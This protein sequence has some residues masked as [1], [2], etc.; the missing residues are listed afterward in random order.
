MNAFRLRDHGASILVSAL[1]GS[2]GVALLQITGALA[3][4][5]SADD[6]TGSS[7]TVALMLTIVAGVFIAIATYVGAIV[8]ANTFATIIAGRTRTIALR[9][10]IGST[11][12]AE[13]R[14]VA[15]E[16]LIVGL[17]GAAIGAVAGTAFA[18]AL[19]TTGVHLDQLPDLAYTLFSPVLLIPVV[20]VV[21]TTWLASWIGSRRVLT[22]SPIQATGAAQERSVDEL[23]RHRVR[24]GISVTLFVIGTALLVLG[25]L[26]G[27]VSPL[28]VLIGVVGGILSFTGVALGA[29]IIMPPALRVVGRMLGSSPNAR[30]AAENSVRYPERSSRMTIGLVIAVSLVT[31]FVVAVASFQRLIELARAAQPETYAGTEEMLTVTVLVFSVLVGFS[32]IIAAV[33]MVNTLSLSVL[34][35]TRELGLLRALGFTARQLR[36]MIRAEALQLSAAALL[37]GLV[38]GI[39]YGWAGAQ[40]LLGSAAGVPGIVLPVVPFWL[41]LSVVAGAAILT[42]GASLVP[43][44]RAM[45]IVPVEALAVE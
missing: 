30:L 19:V 35:R 12:A 28:G 15:S 21:L 25:M 11:A 17:I 45:R 27:L 40:S 32:A 31:M 1:A 24:T 20:T 14:R 7:G 43:S 6:V 26:V 34:Q 2:F 42:V 13:R 10:L 22:V 38:L 39:G 3:Q 16:G 41:V 5:I 23:G 8:T 29:T 4:A 44:R 37:V 18:A 33:G 36:G 9:R